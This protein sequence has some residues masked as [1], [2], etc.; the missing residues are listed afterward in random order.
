MKLVHAQTDPL[1]G[2]HVGSGRPAFLTAHA[3]ANLVAYSDHMSV[4]L[5]VGAFCGDAMAVTHHRLHEIAPLC[6][7]PHAQEEAAASINGLSFSTTSPPVLAVVRPRSAEFYLIISA[8]E[9][10]KA[11]LVHAV[12]HTCVG[13]LGWTPA[14][15]NVAL[16]SAVRVST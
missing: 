1:F 10:F 9:G 2:T 5:Y 14:A 7:A 15:A 11:Q 16:K 3:K 12:D 6:R 8:G 13:V 4:H